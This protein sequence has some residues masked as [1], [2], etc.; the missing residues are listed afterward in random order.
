MVLEKNTNKN[1]LR[2]SNPETRNYYIKETS[3][4]SWSVSTLERNISSQY[5][6]RLLL[7][8]SKEFVKKEMEEK[9]KEFQL[10][11]MEF[12]KNPA[13]LEFL[14]LP[15]NIGYTECELEKAIINK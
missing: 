7:S 11:K 2:V 6:E 4:N 5:Y 10:D 9:T 13:I 12:I 3:E 15:S 1:L 8:H 14:N